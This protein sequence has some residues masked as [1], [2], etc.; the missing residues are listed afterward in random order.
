[1]N[2]PRLL[3]CAALALSLLAV[4][5]RAAF[6][7][8]DET[9]CAVEANGEG[10]IKVAVTRATATVTVLAQEKTVDDLNNALSERSRALLA[11]LQSQKA[12]NVRTDVVQISPHFDFENNVRKQNG[13]DGRITVRFESDV[14]EAG[15]LVSGALGNGA[16]EV[17]GVEISP[18][19]KDQDQARKAAISLA[20]QDALSQARAAL[21]AAGLRETKIRHLSVNV[22]GSG[23]VAT[24]KVA[25]VAMAAPAGA[26]LPVE[27]G[28]QEIVA[29][30]Q[31]TLEF[32]KK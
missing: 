27:G 2:T 6:W 32:E 12:E 17:E 31:A 15:A 25:R 8:A 16:N 20:V 21:D 10:R 9:A 28:T 1:M 14:K 30:V 11:F 24:F 26:P 3:L 29:T 4:P 23:P 22:G 19:D 5:G 18:S 7:K 13:F